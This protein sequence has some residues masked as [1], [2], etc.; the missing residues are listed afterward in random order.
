MVAAVVGEEEDQRPVGDLRVVQLR[1]DSADVLVQAVHH[2]GVGGIAL[3]ARFLHALPVKLDQFRLAL[4]G[5]V[6]GVI[7]LVEEERLITAG[8]DEFQ[9]FVGQPIREIVALLGAGQVHLVGQ[10]IPARRRAAG[11]AGNVDVEA[12]VLRVIRLSAEVP[13]A[14]AG[15]DVAGRLQ[16]FR[17][18]DFFQRQL[19]RVRG[20]QKFR[21]GRAAAVQPDGEIQPGRILARMDTCPR[22]RT[23]AAGRIR[24]GEP[25]ALPGQPIQV[26]SPVDAIAVA[27]QIG[28]AQVVGEDE[29]DVRRR[30]RGLPG[31]RAS[32]ECN[33]GHRRQRELN[34]PVVSHFGP[35]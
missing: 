2:G 5:R 10:K 18:R 16:R 25:H 31:G 8:I 4:N 6:D 14:D 35:R 19:L 32:R 26:G 22:R 27:A 21:G 3:P 15:G 30:G 1:H 9:G 24:V 20:I 33:N 13:F 23:D 7:R 28:P 12:L 34:K 11:S 29:D 17:D